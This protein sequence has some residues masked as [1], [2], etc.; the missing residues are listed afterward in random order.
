MKPLCLVA[1]VMLRL[2]AART[3]ATTR[4]GLLQAAASPFSVGTLTAQGINNWLLEVRDE[5][6]NPLPSQE[7]L[8]NNA[9]YA[10]KA[11]SE[12]PAASQVP[13]EL[14]KRYVLPYRQLDE[15]VDEWR[16]GFYE[17]LGPHAAGASSLR[18]VVEAVVPRVF[19]D[20][21]ASHAV[22]GDALN[23]SHVVFQANCTPGIMAPVSETLMRGHA[24]C[25]G[26]SI[27]VANGLRSVGVPARVVGTPQW[28]THE[29]G[30]HNW[31]E[32][33]T[34]ET[35]DGWA[36]LD[37][38]PSFAQTGV[39]LNQGWF[40]PSNTRVAES[41]GPHAIFAAVWDRT[42]ATSQYPYGW[43]QPA[44]EWPAEDR[45]AFYKSL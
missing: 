30:N 22:M 27:L 9:Q 5:K 28:N 16:Q 26:C 8:Q 18:E 38:D 37:A 17:V 43:R 12:V 10:M 23:Q 6:Q 14:F 25:S 1:A 35:G 3:I 4:T 45:T 19:T 44:T 20:L 24:S 15:P 31:V 40:V 11:R 2:A 39:K 32:V 41:G 34:N 29:G 21:R 36:F 7:Y 33:W 13:E 42:S